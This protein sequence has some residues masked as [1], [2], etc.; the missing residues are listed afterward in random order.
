MR[1]GSGEGTTRRTP[2]PSGASVQP[3]LAASL[4]PTCWAYTG[5][6]GFVGF[7]KAGSSPSTSTMVSSVATGASP[8]RPESSSSMRNPIIPTLWAPSTSSGYGSTWGKAS[9]WRASRPTWGPLPW[10]ITTR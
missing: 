5:P 10:V 7:P 2:A 8:R 4:R 1:F 6:I 3:R 9:A